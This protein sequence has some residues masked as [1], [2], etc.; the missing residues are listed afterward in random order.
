[1]IILFKKERNIMGK[2]KQRPPQYNRQSMGYQQNV[3]KQQMKERDVQLPKQIDMEKIKKIYKYGGI[4]WIIL[5]IVLAI[6]VSIK[7]LIPMAIIALVAVGAVVLY[8]RSYE[9]KYLTAYKKMGL[10][11][12]YFLKQMRKNGSDAKSIA[13]ISKKWDKIKVD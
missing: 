2:G 12:E 9:N 1:M 7:T 8:L 3:Y 10:T 5:T 11:K 6:F 4:A 13:K